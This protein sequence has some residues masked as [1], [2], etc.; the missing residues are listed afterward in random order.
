MIKYNIWVGY[1]WYYES[2]SDIGVLTYAI[3]VSN[4]V[5]ILG[6][7]FHWPDFNIWYF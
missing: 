6:K 4:Y 3:K 2:N 5:R 7:S 1:A